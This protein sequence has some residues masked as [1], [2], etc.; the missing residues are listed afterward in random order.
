MGMT[1]IAVPLGSVLAFL[2]IRTDLPG[3]GWLEPLLLVPIF[4]SPVVLSLGYIVAVGPVGFITIWAKPFLGE[5]PWNL[6]S[7]TSIVIIAGHHPHPARLPLRLLGAPL[8]GARPGGGGAHRRRR[9]A[10]GGAST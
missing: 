8:G 9:P 3:R 4:V 5:T 7:L 10:P 1:A 6:Y 2:M